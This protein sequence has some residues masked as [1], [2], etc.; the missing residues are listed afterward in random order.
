ML[1]GIG[2]F[3][4]SGHGP[5]GTPALVRADND[6]VKVRPANPG[7]T[8]VPN[9]DN[10]VFQTMNGTDTGDGTGQDKLITGNEEPVDV[11]G[12]AVSEDQTPTSEDEGDDDT[13]A[14]AS[15]PVAA[16]IA[17]APKGEDRVPATNQAAAKQQGAGDD[18][19]VMPRRVRTMV[20]KPDGSL[21]PSDDKVSAAEPQSE[22]ATGADA[23]ALETDDAATTDQ[24]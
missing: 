23:S 1:G 3:A 24:P 10:K 5:G 14:S 2:A 18:I 7:G 13:V 21:M 9:Q 4:L 19:A 11:N 17:A 6:P 22:P 16:E 8:T 20:V 12:R 15:D